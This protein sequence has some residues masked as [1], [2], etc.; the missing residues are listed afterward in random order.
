MSTSQ[1]NV[2][3]CKS[4]KNAVDSQFR[5]CPFCGE[6]I[7]NINTSGLGFSSP[8]PKEVTGWN[9]G[10]FLLPVIWGPFNEV[11]FSLLSIIPIGS[12]VM[13]IVLGVKGN[14]WAWQC[15]K[16][17]SIEQFKKTQHKWMI[18][19]VISLILPVIL[20]LGLILIAIGILGYFKV[21]K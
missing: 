3:Y 9:W 15:K 5:Y 21:I 16:W 20:A 17:D 19:G 14:D 18:W 11:W 7:Q 2:L 8:V 12:V 4:C 6:S 1:S 13:P 10:A